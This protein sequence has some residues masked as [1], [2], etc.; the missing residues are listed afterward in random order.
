MTRA[1]R[2]RRISGETQIDNTSLEEQ[3]KEINKY[4]LM[5]G[6]TF[7]DEHLYTDVM[8]GIEQAWRDRF[9]L[10][11]MLAASKRNE[12]DVVVIHHTDRLAR[13]EPLIIIMEELAYHGGVTVESTQQN[14]ED[15]DEGRIILHFLSLSSKAEWKRIV[16]RTSDGRRAAAGKNQILGAT[17]SYGYTWNKEHTG[18]ILNYEIIH[19][20]PDGTKWTEVA[21]IAFIFAEAKAGTP[22]TAIGKKLQNKGI[23]TRKGFTYWHPSTLSNMLKNRIYIGEFTAFRNTFHYNG[24]RVNR[25]GKTVANYKRI[26]K[27]LSEHH[28]YPEGTVPAII[29]KET[30]DFIQ[31]QLSYNQKTSRRNNRNYENA[32]C[33]AGIA[34]CGHCKGK[35]H[36]TSLT[37]NP[38]Q[39]VCQ[40]GNLKTGKCQGYNSIVVNKADTEVWKDVCK[41]IRN[42]DLLA[43]HIAALRT[44][45]PTEDHQVPIAIRKKNVETEIENLVELAKKAKSNA[46]VNKIAFILQ[47]SEE[48]LKILEV[49]E[50]ILAGE[51]VLWQE[52]Q[53][54][55]DKFY[56]WCHEW[57]EKLEKASY[58]DKRVCLEYLGVKAKIFR[59]GSR[60][61]ITVT[62]APPKIVEKL[63]VVSLQF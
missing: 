6:Y 53:D 1:A 4:C 12:F 61:R 44:P 30:F 21:V 62:Y 18:Y 38:L 33:R 19:T 40:Q 25:E 56:H 41:L 5:K 46:A 2:Y 23:P 28:H 13:G 36:V 27:P 60:P 22:L 57:V 32:L 29:D 11:R 51:H 54:E 24:T 3:L 43:Q 49:E 8:T 55:I 50:K 9:D 31:T 37:H 42:P 58:K 45:D 15:T 48:E 26:K 17:P 7:S 16:K 47:Q 20:E 39:Y 10:Q 35:M 52:A 59:Y 63:K 34:I 14:I